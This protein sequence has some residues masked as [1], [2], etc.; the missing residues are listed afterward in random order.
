L[1]HALLAFHCFSHQ[2]PQPRHVTYLTKSIFLD[3]W[4]MVKK[5]FKIQTYLIFK[6]ERELG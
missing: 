5:R 2:R 3:G 1:I 6:N 4:Y